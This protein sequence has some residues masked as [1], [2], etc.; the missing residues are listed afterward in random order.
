MISNIEEGR[1]EAEEL[2]KVWHLTERYSEVRK[3]LFAKQEDPAEVEETKT[4]IAD[5]ALSFCK[6]DLGWLD[7]LLH[8]NEERDRDGAS[9]RFPGKGK[10]IRILLYRKCAQVALSAENAH[11]IRRINALLL[12]DPI[13]LIVEKLIRIQHL[14]YFELNP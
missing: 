4:T 3:V 5:F 8:E 14:Y 10:H 2:E 6:E 1:V 7:E 11:H 12:D 13:M 9:N